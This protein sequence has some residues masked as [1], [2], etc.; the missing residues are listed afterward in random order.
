MVISW[1]ITYLKLNIKNL[2]YKTTYQSKVTPVKWIGPCTEE[3]I[4][5][6]AVEKDS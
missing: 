2:D 5:I 6:A 3:E 1:L 4:K